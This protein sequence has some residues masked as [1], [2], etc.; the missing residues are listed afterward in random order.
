MENLILLIKIIAVC[1]AAGLLGNWFSVEV[2]KTK[3]RGEPPYKAYGT[4]PGILIIL[5]IIFLPIVA[6]WLQHFR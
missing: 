5:L 1:I 3:A 2:K 4:A 6:W